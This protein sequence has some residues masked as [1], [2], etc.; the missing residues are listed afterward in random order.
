MIADACVIN[1]I[2]MK[3]LTTEDFIK[4][5]REIHGDKYDYSKVNYINNTTP[6]TIICPEHGEFQQKPCVH[7]TGHGCPACKNVKQLDTAE[8][9]RRAKAVHGDKYDY[10]LSIYKNKRTK[11]IVICPIHGQ[12][13][14]LPMNHTK[15]QGC[16]KCGKDKAIDRI[17]DYRNARKT[18]E[19][20]QNDLN[21]MYGGQYEIVGDYVNNKTYTE[22]FCHKKDKNGKGHGIFVTRPDG[23][24][25]GHGCPKCF[26]TISQAEI[27][28]VEFIKDNYNG[29]IITHDRKILNGK[30]LDI[31]L[32]EKKIAIEYD[33]LIWHSEKYRDKTDIL[34][35]HNECI[36]KGIR[37]IN[38]F[39]DE[40]FEH[41]AICK[42]KIKSLLNLNAKI[43]ARKCDIRIVGH[44][45]AF[46][47]LNDNHLQGSIPSKHNIGLYYNNELISI[48]TFGNLRKNL[49]S[50]SKEGAYEML[51]FCNKMGYNVIG[52]ASKLLH[53]FIERYNPEEIISYADRRWSDGNMYKK[54]G[55]T[56]DSITQQN[57]FYV[58]PN[59]QK[60]I[61]R[62]SL[63]KNILVKK[64]GCPANKTE[65]E[66]C[67]KMGFYRIYD[68]G[69]LKY[70]WKNQN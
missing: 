42:S 68:C 1:G 60:R 2:K 55:F 17:G 28:I 9:I 35:K 19:E 15:G 49:G 63:R 20:F 62:F 39:E 57:Y 23:L 41:T 40:W 47:F 64:F 18:K 22:I 12:F 38:I 56:E 7:L 61:N 21:R 14:Q 45:E 52:G 53:F 13:E 66:Y 32:P 25:N 27:D 11:V 26:H 36:S 4:A 44:R 10:S 6:V 30:E 24:I 69:C 70:V 50:T 8:F 46:Y 33:G 54:L 5:A 31:F 3:R 65:K 59:G 43:Y 48:M 51:R 67:E 58:F 34:Y 29:E 16:P 37:L